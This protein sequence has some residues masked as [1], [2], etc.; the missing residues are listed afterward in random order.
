MNTT[1]FPYRFRI[2]RYA[3]DLPGDISIIM[4]APSDEIS[5]A[6]L[7]EIR[8]ARKGDPLAIFVQD[9]L[10]DEV[11]AHQTLGCFLTQWGAL[12]FALHLLLSMLLNTDEARTRAITAP[13]AGKQLRD[14]I[15]NVAAAALGSAD[16]KTL[17]KLLERFSGAATHRNNIIHGDWIG[18]IVV[19]QR[20]KVVEI[21]IVV[22]RQMTPI[23]PDDINALPNPKNQKL[24]MKHL[25][26]LKRII[27]HI[28]SN[29]TLMQDVNA[30]IRDR[31]PGT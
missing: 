13:L 29:I 27:G 19:W 24:R 26:T 18:E 12:E 25:Y 6:E 17:R 22:V 14:M 9:G 23:S 4:P 2:V 5:Q 16:Q 15:E 31:W 28:Q 10:P 20:R 8:A 3:Q 30:F 7:A 21:R 11:Q 1:V